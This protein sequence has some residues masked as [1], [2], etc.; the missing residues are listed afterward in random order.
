MP[1]L[2]RKLAIKGSPFPLTQ[3]KKLVKAL[4]AETA[5]N[6]FDYNELMM[7]P[8]AEAFSIWVNDPPAEA[9]NPDEWK[10]YF[11]KLIDDMIAGFHFVNSMKSILS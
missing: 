4:V 10:A 11:E 7:P 2:A 1:K 5:A 9:T 3:A 8:G 6:P